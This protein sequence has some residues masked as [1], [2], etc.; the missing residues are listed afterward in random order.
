MEL[1]FGNRLLMTLLS[2]DGNYGFVKH[3]LDL[4]VFIGI[5]LVLRNHCVLP[6][7]LGLQNLP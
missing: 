5:F 2:L 4:F 3:Q 1:A 6:I 7:V